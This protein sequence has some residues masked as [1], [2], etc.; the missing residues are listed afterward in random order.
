M[1]INTLQKGAKN[2]DDDDDDDNK[3]TNNFPI[4]TPLM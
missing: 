1:C 3:N 4:K 2:D